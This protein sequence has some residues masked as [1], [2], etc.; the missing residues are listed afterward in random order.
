MFPMVSLHEN[1]SQHPWRFSK[2]I[3]K[4]FSFKKSNN[5]TEM[6]SRN[7]ALCFECRV[8]CYKKTVGLFNYFGKKNFK[9]V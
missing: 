7:F 5:F 2:A 9:H 1:S 4:M 3:L 8:I 6:L